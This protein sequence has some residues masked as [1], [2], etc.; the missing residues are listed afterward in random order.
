MKKLLIVIAL[1][2]P[3]FLQAQWSVF[4]EFNFDPFKS[5]SDDFY[6]S[7]EQDQSVIKELR[8][9]L[10]YKLTNYISIQG[11]LTRLEKRDARSVPYFQDYFIA[12]SIPQFM[13]LTLSHSSGLRNYSVFGGLQLDFNRLHIASHVH[14]SRGVF[15]DEAIAAR[16]FT[17]FT[18]E[19]K[20]TFFEMDYE[21]I[22]SLKGDLNLSF[23]L[24]KAQKGTLSISVKYMKDFSEDQKFTVSE[25][26]PEVRE[27]VENFPGSSYYN[28][29]DFLQGGP[30][31]YD[32][33]FWGVGI[34]MVYNL[35]DIISVNE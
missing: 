1:G 20:E 10:N 22:N 35:G 14:F 7:H 24:L 17:T 5:V 4:A 2:F 8:L 12:G 3:V 19:V 23:D 28:L 6:Q 11:G 16:E 32:R 29:D 21:N 27:M 25:Y 13:N 15:K 31:Y 33:E 9:G 18:G 30:L 26:S 34:R